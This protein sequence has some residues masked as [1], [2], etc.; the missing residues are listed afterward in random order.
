MERVIRWL[1]YTLTLNK[2][3]VIFKLRPTTTQTDIRWCPLSFRCTEVKATALVKWV[4]LISFDSPQSTVTDYWRLS[5]SLVFSFN[6]R[7][8]RRFSWPPNG[9]GQAIIFSSFFILLLFP[10]L[11]SAVAELDVYH[12]STHGVALVGNNSYLE[13]T[14]EM[15]CT[16][17]AE[18][19]G[20]KK[21][22]KIC[23]LRTIHHR[24]T[25]SGCIFATK[26]Y[27]VNREK[28]C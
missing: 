11:I 8:V 2:W 27:S 26:A 14:P 20:H 3:A 7:I 22:P 12:T 1:A 13:C 24:T 21:S 4:E 10:R 18:N 17:L 15:C 19:T 5:N 6:F 16:R 23:H 28:S 9:I 25:L